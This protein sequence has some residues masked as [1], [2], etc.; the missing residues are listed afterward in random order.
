MRRPLTTL[1]AGRSG[2]GLFA[3]VLACSA[4]SPWT[5]WA[6]WLY[7]PVLTVLA[8]VQSG[9][10]STWV[11]LR[12][13]APGITDNA[14]LER[15]R[16]AVE[17]ANA[18]Y[19]RAQVEA[20]DLRRLVGGLSRFR[21]L[22]PMASDTVVIAP[23]IGPAPDL[24]GGLITVRAG[25]RDGVQ[26]DSVAVVHGVHVVGQ[27]KRVD[28]KTS[29]VLPVTFLGRRAGGT[30]GLG[31]SAPT[32]RGVVMLD[33]QRA[34]PFCSLQPTGEGTLRGRVEDVGDPNAPEQTPLALGM[35]VRLNDEAWAAGSRMLILGTITAIEPVPTSPLRKLVT[36]TPVYTVE[37]WNQVMIR[38]PG[39][40]TPAAAGGG[41]P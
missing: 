14:E 17:E 3:V 25:E 16:L 28:E 10:R 21:D 31:G 26:L 19:L 34:G 38:V 41:T 33:E 4:L 24:S 29:G 23:V 6:S 32:V 35:T 15:M 11:W 20:D 30:G 22:N 36:V 37:R 12:G 18:R 27:V 2:L 9:V 13:P 7:N 1:L 8:P 39:A 40:A 5:G